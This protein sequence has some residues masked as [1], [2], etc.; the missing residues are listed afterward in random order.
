M[1][2]TTGGEKK[3]ISKKWKKQNIK[4]DALN[5]G[6]TGNG[7]PTLLPPFPSTSSS[8]LTTSSSTSLQQQHISHFMNEG[9]FQRPHIVSVTGVFPTPTQQLQQFYQ[10][11]HSPFDPAN[12]SVHNLGQ[13]Y[14]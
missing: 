13:H 9:N 10:Q 5:L 14:P 3:K 6:S 11:Q 1:D 7:I 2:L 4:L 8:T 12:N